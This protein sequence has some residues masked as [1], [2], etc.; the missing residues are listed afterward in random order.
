MIWTRQSFFIPEARVNNSY[1]AALVHL[2]LATRGNKGQGNRQGS[3][4]PYDALFLNDYIDMLLAYDTARLGKFAEPNVDRLIKKQHKSGMFIDVHNR[5]NDDIVTSHGQ[6]RFCLAYHYIMTRDDEYAKKVYPAVRKAVKLIIHDHKT[7][8]HGLIRPPIPYDAP[9]LT[10][11]GGLNLKER[12]LFLF[13]LISPAWDKPGN[14]LEIRN[15]AT[16][17]GSVSATMTFTKVGADV[18]IASD[19][20]T[21]PAHL[22]LTIP[23]FVELKSYD[24]GV[25]MPEIKDGVIYFS[26]DVKK[27]TLKW[28][29]REDAHNGTYQK[30]LKMYRSEYGYIKDRNRYRTEQPPKLVLT[31]QEDNHPPAEMLKQARMAGARHIPC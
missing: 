15:A 9:M 25:R 7:N 30:L 11:Q 19:F 18:R 27:I 31:T 5:G 16:E 17:M 3:G 29:E 23:Y 22:G 14:K 21:A 12:N 24:A 10:G 2:L 13:S 20:H 1:K 6:G 28:K 26:P 4:L 8:K